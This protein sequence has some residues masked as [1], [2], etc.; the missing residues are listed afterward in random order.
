M[1]IRFFIYLEQAAK[2]ASQASAAGEQVK[3]RA[4]DAAETVQSAA[5]DAAEQAQEQSAGLLNKIYN[6]LNDVKAS[7]LGKYF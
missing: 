7:I 5:Q 3:R 2:L 6:V 4:S 1:L